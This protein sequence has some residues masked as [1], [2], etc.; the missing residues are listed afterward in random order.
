ML[1]AKQGKEVFLTVANEMGTLAKV[2]KVVAER[3]INVLA[4][5]CWVDVDAGYAHLVTDDTLRTVEALQKAGYDAQ[6]QEVILIEAR[7]KPG[8]LLHIASTLAD[9]KLDVEYLYAS[10][11]VDQDVCLVVLRASNNDRALVHLNA[12]KQ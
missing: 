4:M 7:H 6:E 5:T 12:R 1:T 9:N 2:A 11:T 8:I 3:G 10:A